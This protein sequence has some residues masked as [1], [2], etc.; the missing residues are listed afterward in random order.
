MLGEQHGHMTIL[1]WMGAR[2]LTCREKGVKGI[3]SI[4]YAEYFVTGSSSM[5]VL[6]LNS[7]RS[8]TEFS[9]TRTGSI[10]GVCDTCIV[11]KIPIPNLKIQ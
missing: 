9:A 7:M 6:I 10:L 3:R 1:V 8:V 11:L 5:A 2:Q 4:S